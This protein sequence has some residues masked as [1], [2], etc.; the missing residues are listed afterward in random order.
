MNPLFRLIVGK[1]LAEATGLPPGDS[2]RYGLVAA[3]MPNLTGL[4]VAKAMAERAA[5]ARQPVA[6]APPPQL[7]PVD[8]PAQPAPGK[9]PGP[10]G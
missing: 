9:V 8:R 4:V 1:R 6:E 10:G 2:A 5:A 3:L 7:P